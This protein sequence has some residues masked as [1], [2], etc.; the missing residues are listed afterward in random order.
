MI[1]NS[2]NTYSEVENTKIEPCCGNC[3]YYVDSKGGFCNWNLYHW[4]A[5]AIPF[6]KRYPEIIYVSKWQGK[7]CKA[8]LPKLK[9]AST[10]A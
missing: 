4:G 10:S 2:S 8:W 9:S 5:Q 1:T 6:W 7:E 3:Y